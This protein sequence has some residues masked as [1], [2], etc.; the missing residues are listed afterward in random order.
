MNRPTLLISTV[1]PWGRFGK[2]RADF[3]AAVKT[4]AEGGSGIASKFWDWTE[5]QIKPYE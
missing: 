2:L 4:E 1:I 3:E 5:E